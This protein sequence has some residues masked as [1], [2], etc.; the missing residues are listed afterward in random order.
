MPTPAPPADLT[1]TGREWAP[2]R[3]PAAAPGA[4]APPAQ[5][6]RE[7]AE[8][9]V[10]PWLWSGVMGLVLLL[11][12][13]GVVFGEGVARMQSLIG[14]FVA[15]AFF[16]IA[17]RTARS[18]AVRRLGWDELGIADHDRDHIHRVPWAEVQRFDR[19]PL[20]QGSGPNARQAGWKWVAAGHADEVLFELVEPTEPAD[21]I[22]RLRQRIEAGRGGRRG[23]ARG[24]GGADA[25]PR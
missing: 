10:A 22:R 15:G 16:V 1:W 5:W 13:S 17:L 23:A 25:A 18:A 21:A 24:D 8:A 20:R 3:N 2:T 7:G 12:V 14:G 11:A 19:L 6:L 4:Q 9:R